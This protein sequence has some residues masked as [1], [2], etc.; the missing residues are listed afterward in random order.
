MCIFLSANRQE[1]NISEMIIGD[2][3]CFTK[4]Y[5]V[6]A[7]IQASQPDKEKKTFYSTDFNALA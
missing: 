1:K 6:P 7:V 5:T 2:F 4:S 3:H